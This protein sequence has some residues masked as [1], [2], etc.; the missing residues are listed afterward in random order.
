MVTAIGRVI[1]SMGSGLGQN[2]LQ[3]LALSLTSSV[4]L[5][6]SLHQFEP[7]FTHLQNE[8]GNTYF[9]KLM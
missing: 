1:K 9:V 4:A 8:D 2:S 7:Q 3:I 5:G 6:K